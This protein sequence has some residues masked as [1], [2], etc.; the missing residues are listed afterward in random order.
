MTR[1]LD[2]VALL[3]IAAL[4]AAV[5]A[6]AQSNDGTFFLEGLTQVRSA[7]APAALDAMSD[8]VGQWDVTFTT[9]PTDS[10]STSQPAQAIITTMNRGH[11]YM[12]RLFTADFDGSGQ[13]R[14]TMT[15]LTFTPS[16]NQWT[17]GTVDSFTES[18]QLFNGDLTDGNLVVRD[19]QR[20]LGS[21]FLV[22]YRVTITP[23]GPDRFTQELHTSTDYGETWRARITK[24]YARRA[25]TDGFMAGLSSFGSPAANL[26][27]EARQ[28]DFMIGE[29]TGQNTINQPGGQRAQWQAT[30]TAGY[31]L[32]GHAVLEYHWFDTDPGLPDA[33]TT[34]VRIYN[35]AMRRWDCLYLNN[36]GNSPLYFG[37]SMDGDE[38]VLH[39]FTT[40]TA[41]PISR[42]VFHSIEAD[43]YQWYGAT[44]TDRG[45]SFAKGWIIDI[46]RND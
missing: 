9:Y 16:A 19:A 1:L 46:K 6:T 17:M 25:E 30:A 14:S 44:S 32:N 43:R 20:R 7:G 2:L 11:G 23:D 18:V 3:S 4:I 8:L 40:D 37:G 39:S 13:E 31:V 42:Y 29:W 15:F 34:I 10:T 22:H 38:M 27:K 35:R 28:F 24:T 5:P 33:A 12:E 41:S 26:P 45:D 36:R 21:T